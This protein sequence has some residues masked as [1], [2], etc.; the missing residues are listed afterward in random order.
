MWIMATVNGKSLP[1]ADGMTTEELLDREGYKKDRVVIELNGEILPKAS[2]GSYV[3][4]A[5]DKIEIV[6][7]V[8][9]G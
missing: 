9:G 4:C 5:E 6:S 7:F 3:I 2:C 8:G 1:Y